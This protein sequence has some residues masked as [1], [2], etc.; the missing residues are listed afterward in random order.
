M[1][2]T[3]VNDLR[4]NELGTGDA[5]GTWG[6]I[7]NTNLELIGEGLSYGTEDCFTSDADDTAT[8]ADGATDPARAMY[9][10][11]TSSATL[12]ATRTLTIA[13]NT[14]SRLQYIENATTGDQ[15][16]NISQGSG[17]NVTIPSG[18]TK[19]VYMDGAGATA[20]VVDAFSLLNLNLADNVKLNFGTGDDLQIYHTGT[21][22]II[23]DGGTGNLKIYGENLELQ[24]TST[25]ET[26]F[27]AIAN[28]AVTLYYDNSPKLATNS[29]GIDVTGNATFADDG[30]AIFGADSDLQIY[31]NG[32]DSYIDNNSPN[33][34][35]IRN[36]KDDHDVFIQSDDGS[37]GLATYFLADGST[38]EAQLFHYGSQK[39]NTTSTG[40][41][42]TG[43]ALA[44]TDTDT[45]NTGSVTLDFQTNQ[46]FVLTLT[47]NVTLDNPTTEQVGQSGFIVFIQDGTGGRTV[48]LGTDYETA[49]GAGLT[50]SSAPST[51]DI[52]PYVV[53]A[54]GRILLGTPQLAFS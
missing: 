40:I 22:S 16:I 17:S 52:V 35:Y 2:S 15:S 29:T 31:H 24:A 6:T 48:S 21:E 54:S 53:A 42:V 11:V 47:G 30:K 37:G 20:A 25:G 45:T 44:T 38:G 3:Y 5:A 51:T 18:Q 19:A 46:N 8:I 39:L 1:A 41:E 34:L 33:H 26:Y 50:L 4:L 7:T 36:A 49:G 27:N 14:V 10:K 28:G 23:S 12:T 32:I 9:F 43:T 13:P